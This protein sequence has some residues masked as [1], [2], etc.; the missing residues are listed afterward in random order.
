MDKFKADWQ[1]AAHVTALFG[2]QLSTARRRYR[3]FVQKGI[4]QGKRDDLVGGGLVRSA[5]G[6]AAVKALRKAKKYRKGDE[7]RLGDGEIV[8]SVIEQAKEIFEQKHCLKAEGVDLDFIAD[9]GAKVI[10][11]EPHLIWTKG[12]QPEIVKSRSL[13][14]CIAAKVV[15]DQNRDKVKFSIHDARTP[16]MVGLLARLDSLRSK[17]RPWAQNEK[18]PQ[19][20]A[21]EI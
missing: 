21:F 4:A 18:W 9:K 15:K 20:L 2:E 3:V 19:R 12:K 7:R 14:L 10:G 11:I 13:L 1:D 5:G 16:A 6:W 8:Q 17:P